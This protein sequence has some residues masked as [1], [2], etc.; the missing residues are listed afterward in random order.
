MKKPFLIGTFLVLLNCAVLA[1]H[2]LRESS[3]KIEPNQS[4]D[5]V[6]A[7]LGTPKNR[8]FEGNNEAWQY[9]ETSYTSSAGD[10]Y[11]TVWFFKGTVTGITTYK[12][13]NYGS[14]ESFFKTIRWEDAPKIIIENR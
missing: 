7:I 2:V 8:Q 6:L 1:P 4:K 12:N 14:C 3:V 5:D 11:L 10:D 13:H 9:C